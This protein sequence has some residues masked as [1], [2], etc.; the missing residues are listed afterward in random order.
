MKS[1]DNYFYGKWGKEFAE[2]HHREP[3]SLSGQ[4]TRE[5]DPRTDFG[6]TLCKLPQNGSQEEGE[7][8]HRG[9]T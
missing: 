2:V 6:G 9:R 1:K 4:E 3:L 7:S 8:P 5:T